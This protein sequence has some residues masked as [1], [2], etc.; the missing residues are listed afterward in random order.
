LKILQLIQ[1]PQRRGAEIFTVQLSEELMANGHEIKLVALFAHPQEIDFSGPFSLLNRPLSKRFFD[2]QGWLQLCRLIQ[3]FQP[4]FVQANAADTLKFAV[5]SKLFF[6][7]NSKLIYRNANQM[8]DF[9]RGFWHRLFNLFL[10]NRVDGVVSVSEASQLD[11]LQ[12]FRF[13]KKKCI[14]V[15]IGIV[16]GEIETKL[17]EVQT[18]PEI[19]YLLQMGSLVPEKDPLAMLEIFE[20]LCKNFPHLQLVYLGSGRLSEALSSQIQQRGWMDKVRIIPNQENIF[21]L[22]AQAK[23]LVMPSK[24]E[25]LPAVILEAM[26]CRVPVVAFGVGG[27]GEVLKS[28]NTG[29]C[30]RPGDQKGFVEA[31]EEVLEID[32]G[33][34]KLILDAAAELITSDYSLSVIASRFERFYRQI[35]E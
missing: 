16:P 10:V 31:V 19:P 32:E 14:A 4:D 22:L 7:W 21:P 15:P 1:K 34:K 27:I 2:F 3:E 23:A 20:C 9:I 26:Y 30:V 5:F 6:G 13:P 29:W 8:G 24:I 18:L 35:L 12:T 25:G 33:R 28:G 11:F 17:G